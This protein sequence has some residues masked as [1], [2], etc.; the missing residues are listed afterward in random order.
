MCGSGGEGVVTIHTVGTKQLG[1]TLC[2]LEESLD[3]ILK[4]MRSHPK[5]SSRRVPDL[6]HGLERFIRRLCGGWM[7]R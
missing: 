1:N 6:I 2:S 5:L 4:T 3:I 7:R